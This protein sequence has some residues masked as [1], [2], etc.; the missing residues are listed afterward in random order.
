MTLRYD[1]PDLS[2]DAIMRLVKSFDDASI[3]TA[4]SLP[5]E[6]DWY[7]GHDPATTST[8]GGYCVYSPRTNQQPEVLGMGYS[9]S[10]ALEQAK[11]YIKFYHPDHV[12][13]AST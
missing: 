8:V 12:L 1:L 10:E 2:N 6:M 9:A 4:P 7:I 5:K 13:K 3:P 11:S